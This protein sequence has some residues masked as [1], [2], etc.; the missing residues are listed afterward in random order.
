MNDLALAT[1]EV[2][3]GVTAKRSKAA[4]EHWGIWEE[5]C[6]ELA[7]NPWLSR[8]IDPVPILQVIMRRV[9]DGRLAPSGNPVSARHSADILRS[10]GQTFSALGT[11]DPHKHPSMGQ[12]NFRLARQERAYKKLD[13]PTPKKT[14]I[15][16]EVL[17][18]AT[19]LARRGA[20]V[21]EQAI[22]DLIWIGFYFLLRPSEYLWTNATQSPFT[23]Q[24]LAF[25]VAGTFIGAHTITQAQLYRH[26]GGTQLY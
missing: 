10:V 20:A 17:F 2:G 24:D 4:I 14:P 1:I 12:T 26:H 13:K 7:L 18:K 8:C 21:R 22:D 15:P 6:G 9:K 3:Q 23:L 11:A 16:R 25:K 19:Q 5:F